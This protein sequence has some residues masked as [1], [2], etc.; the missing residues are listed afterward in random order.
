MF[1]YTISMANVITLAPTMM[2]VIVYRVRS[3]DRDAGVV[4]DNIHEVEDF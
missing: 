3:V 1:T 2:L 4:R